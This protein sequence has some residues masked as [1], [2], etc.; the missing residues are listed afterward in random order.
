MIFKEGKINFVAQLVYTDID[1]NNNPFQAI[2]TTLPS[3]TESGEKN[4]KLKLE[5]Q[6]VPKGP[7]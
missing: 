3:S 5:T 6:N 4:A 2:K 7:Q 1:D